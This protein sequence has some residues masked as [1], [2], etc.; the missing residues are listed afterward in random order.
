MNKKINYE[1]GWEA[2]IDIAE[3]HKHIDAEEYT[4]FCFL[5]QRLQEDEEGNLNFGEH[6]PV[7]SLTAQEFNRTFDIGR[8]GREVGLYGSYEIL[9]RL[10]DRLRRIDIKICGPRYSSKTRY[11]TLCSQIEY[12]E[13][14]QVITIHFTDHIMP[15]LLQVET[16][17]KKFF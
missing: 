5:T 16:F 17:L 2:T 11:I 8:G 4:A 6:L 13:K 15:Y 1:S 12:D 3:F 10:G 14:E 7:Y 9:K